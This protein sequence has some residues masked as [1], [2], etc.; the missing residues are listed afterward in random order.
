MSTRG[1]LIKASKNAAAKAAKNAANA[2]WAKIDA[3]VNA[4]T[5]EQLLEVAKTGERK[6]VIMEDL[7]DTR[8]GGMS[9]SQYVENRNERGFE[10]G[11]TLHYESF[12]CGVGYNPYWG[13]LEFRW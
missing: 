9:P 11:A 6:L 1:E 12:D 7:Q 8:Y 4:V 2:A 13:D 5:K 3:I 10:H